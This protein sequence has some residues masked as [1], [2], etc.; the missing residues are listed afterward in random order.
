MGM[1]MAILAV[2]RDHGL[3]PQNI[4]ERQQFLTGG[5]TRDVHMGVPSVHHRRSPTD[6]IGDDLRHRGLV[7]RD[8]FGRNEN[9]VA[10]VEL[11]ELVPALGHQR[12]CRK[13]LPL[14]ASRDE[15][16]TVVR[17][18]DKLLDVDDRALRNVK[19]PK[20]GGDGGVAMHRSPEEG[21]LSPG[22]Y[23]RIGYLLHPMDVR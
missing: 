20:V 22:R 8:W 1:E 15:K 7:P 18:C 17:Q 13:W 21:D 9:S 14:A 10:V 23:S 19:D 4:E 3:R 6:E 2:N 12:K 16:L 11:D 5:V